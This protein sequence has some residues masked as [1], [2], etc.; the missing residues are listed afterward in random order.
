MLLVK[1]RFN[2]LKVF[3]IAVHNQLPMYHI[4]LNIKIYYN[5]YCSYLSGFYAAG[6]VFF[7]VVDFVWKLLKFN[8]V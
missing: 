6:F 2:F 3:K 7:H 8:Q 5:Y 4:I 1:L